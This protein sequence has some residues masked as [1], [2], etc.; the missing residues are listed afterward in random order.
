MRPWHA[1]KAAEDCTIQSDPDGSAENPPPSQNK[2]R[3][4]SS[5]E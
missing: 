1:S 4:T 2:S 5:G 3:A